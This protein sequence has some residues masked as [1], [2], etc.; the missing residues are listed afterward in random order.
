MKDR[1]GRTIDYM[2][3]SITDRCNLRCKYC[4]P[5]GVKPVSH[6]D[7]LTFEEIREIVCCGAGLGIRHIKITGG[8]PLV[9]KGCCELIRMIKAVPGIEHVTLTTNGILLE[10]YL[11]ELVKSGIDGV[12]IS[13]DTLDEDLY[14]RITGYDGLAIVLRVLNR[15]SAL[16]IPVK[17]NAVS[18]DWSDLGGMMKNGLLENGRMENGIIENDTADNGLAVPEEAL[19][20][21]GG[22]TRPGRLEKNDGWKEIVRLAERYP[23]DVRLIEMMP[24]GYGK[25][26]RTVSHTELLAE[27]QQEFPGM[28][29]EN[30]VHGFGPAVYY[31]VPGFLGSIGL[32]SAV[33][34][35]FCENCN[36]VRLTAQGY[37]K[38]CLC[39]E[40]GVDLRAIL[41]GGRGRKELEAAIR[42][43]IFGKPA[44]HCFEA[45]EKITEHRNMVDIGG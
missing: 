4:M 12:N 25:K 3:I 30:R 1:W 39:Y 44:D 28:E 21:E 37:L 9:R 16:P 14:Q 6:Q 8:E 24:I 40:D 22:Q 43:A 17:I 2:R 41:R 18:M 32:I 45:P 33:H 38:T 7:N 26:Y 15:A 27:M 5:F 35:K 29:R 10:E 31:R 42:E 23:V 36:R 20:E 11:D 34:G 13:L 19:A